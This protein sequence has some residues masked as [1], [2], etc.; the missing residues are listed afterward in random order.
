MFQI[1]D[2]PDE[3]F[4]ESYEEYFG[5]YDSKDEDTDEIFSPSESNSDSD[6]ELPW[7]A[8]SEEWDLACLPGRDEYG[9][10][11]VEPCP[12]CGGNCMYLVKKEVMEDLEDI[13]W[14]DPFFSIL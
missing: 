10:M 3:K 12:L 11:D 14:R 2:Y 5:W 1:W 9:N 7:W 13:K 6:S 8:Y 4:D